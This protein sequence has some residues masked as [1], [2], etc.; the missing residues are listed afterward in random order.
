MLFS[1]ISDTHLGLVQYNSEERENDI[2][3]VFK[4]TI[5]ISIKD[6]VD[7]VIFAGDIFH[8]PNPS[9]TAIMHMAH[10]LKKLKKNNI[11]S[12]FVL[13]EHDISRIRSYP[14]PYV[15]HKLEFSQYIGEG[16][17]TYYKDVLIIGFDKIRKSEMQDFESRFQEVDSIAKEHKGHKILVMH[18]GITEANK[19]AGELSTNDLPKNF[20]YYAMGHLHDKFLKSFSNLKGSIAY[21]GSIELTTSEGIKNTKKG[22]FQV[23]ISGTEA[24]PEWIELNIRPQV[25][26]STNF[27]DLTKTVD[28][29][30]E[31][32]HE[33][34]KKPIIELKIQGKDIQTDLVQAQI[35]RLMPYA[36][37]CSWKISEKLS[38]S[39]VLMEKPIRMDDEMLKLAISTLKSEQLANFAI[40]ELLPLLT[41]N[42]L[43]QASQL[44]V[45]NY[46]QF[47]QEKLK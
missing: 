18:Q 26:A 28:G 42:N 43:E 1:H 21:P 17:P 3:D 34:I 27:E 15:F 25:S 11:D 8:T 7:F 44:I 9:G 30:L 13:G 37:H 35:S 36:L 31:Q 6:H 24:K 32:I 29:I 4:Q 20:T 16:K 2:Y 19:F 46:K 39:S 12:F 41:S 40:K 38:D 33:S 23:D 14:V 5:D 22:F 10:A 45:E 47:K